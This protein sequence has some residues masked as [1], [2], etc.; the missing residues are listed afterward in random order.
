MCI[1]VLY[2]F[3]RSISHYKDNSARYCH[4]Y[5]KL[6]RKVCTCYS[7][8]ILMKSEFSQQ[9][10]VNIPKYQV[11]PYGRMDGYR[12]ATSHFFAIL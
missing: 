11:G 2:K 6:L 5:T 9:I 7:S 10:F 12:E 1:G 4:K 3:D 8:Q